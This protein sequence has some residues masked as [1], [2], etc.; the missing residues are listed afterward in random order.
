MTEGQGGDGWRFETGARG[1]GRGRT[2]GVGGPM[3]Q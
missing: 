3:R 2:W 1:K